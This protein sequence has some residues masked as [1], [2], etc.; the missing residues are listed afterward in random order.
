MTFAEAK[1]TIVPFGKEQ[2]RTLDQ[3]AMT[4]AGLRYLDWLSGQ[5]LYG[6]F[7][8]AIEAYLTDPSIARELEQ[9]MGE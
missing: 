8:E 4:D 5:N 3:V 1:N 2:G 6:R 9:I 7:K